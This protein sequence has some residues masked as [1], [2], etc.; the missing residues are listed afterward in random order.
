MMFIQIEMSSDLTQELFLGSAMQ[1]RAAMIAFWN[2][3]VTI[4]NW[5]AF[6]ASTFFRV[7][8]LN[9]LTVIAVVATLTRKHEATHIAGGVAICYVLNEL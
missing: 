4:T 9:P 7:E 1:F 5:M 2:L 6:C 3:I 8:K